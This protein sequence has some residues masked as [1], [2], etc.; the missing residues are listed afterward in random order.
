MHKFYK[1]VL[2]GDK[3]F[4]LVEVLVAFIILGFVLTGTLHIYQQTQLAWRKIEEKNDVLHSL[5]I[6]LDRMA[7]EV[8]HAKS[9]DDGCTEDTLIFCNAKDE[10]I[11]Y[12]LKQGTVYR[13]AGTAP[14]VPLAN[15]V[16]SIFFTY[17]PGEA[18]TSKCKIIQIEITA[19]TD[20]TEPITMNTSVCI[21]LRAAGG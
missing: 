4:T 2:D 3:G 9:L 7:R 10:T 20:K 11:W 12:S 8:R 6:A 5:R 13:K 15:N 17:L 16:R 18:D 1:R 21:R 19:G 14:S